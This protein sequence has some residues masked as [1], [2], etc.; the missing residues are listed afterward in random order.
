MDRHPP[1]ASRCGVRATRPL[2]AGVLLPGMTQNLR[3]YRRVVSRKKELQKPLQHEQEPGDMCVRVR[4]SI[5]SRHM[6]ENGSKVGKVS[7][8]QA[9]NGKDPDQ[10]GSS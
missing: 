3:I 2:K 5:R 7:E 9:V 1:R 8:K 4:A 6:S 10:G